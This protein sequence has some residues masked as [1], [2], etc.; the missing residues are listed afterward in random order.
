ME[1]RGDVDG[2]RNYLLST[3]RQFVGKAMYEEVS[4][5]LAELEMRQRRYEAALAY[6]RDVLTTKNAALAARARS[7][8]RR[9]QEAAR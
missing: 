9:A 8:M 7:L 6:A 2:A 4:Y 5:E 1:T 3:R